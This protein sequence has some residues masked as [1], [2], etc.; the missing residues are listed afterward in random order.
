MAV[1]HNAAIRRLL[2]VLVECGEDE[3]GQWVL[4]ESLCAGIGLLHGR[5]P[6]QTAEFIELVAER[7]ARGGG[8]FVLAARPHRQ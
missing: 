2:P 1:E 3:A 8:G 5:T 4:I 7:I 6:R